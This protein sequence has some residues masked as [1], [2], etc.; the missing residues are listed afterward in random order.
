MQEN[1]TNEKQKQT[2][3]KMSWAK[4]SFIFRTRV[5]CKLFVIQNKQLKLVIVMRHV[6]KSHI[7]CLEHK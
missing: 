5:W 3:E 1:K 6:A 4:K 2:N 7:M